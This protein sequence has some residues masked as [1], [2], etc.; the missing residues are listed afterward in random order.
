[1]IRRPP[2]STSTDTLFPYTT[3]CRSRHAAE[4]LL[5]ALTEAVPE[6]GRRCR[7][8]G[9]LQGRLAQ[10]LRVLPQRGAEETDLGGIDVVIGEQRR[11]REQLLAA[12]R[13]QDRIERQ[14]P[15][16]LHPLQ[17]LQRTLRPLVARALAVAS[18]R[19]GTTAA[20]VDV[21][22]HLHFGTPG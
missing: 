2:R 18:L 7:E 6:I 20:P 16:R 11:H 13:Q 12:G 8:P 10:E 9:A 5:V 3:L 19:L 4:A 21:G 14:G 15:Q 22:Q 17:P 1:M